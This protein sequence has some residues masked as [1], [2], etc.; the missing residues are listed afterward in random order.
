MQVQRVSK[1]TVNFRRGVPTC[2]GRPGFYIYNHIYI[3]K[4]AA[5]LAAALPPAP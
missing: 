5:S 4:M 3:Y 2:K 1:M